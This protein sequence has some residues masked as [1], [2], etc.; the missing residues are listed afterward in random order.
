MALDAIKAATTPEDAQAAYDAVK[1]DVTAAEGED[2]QMA[3]DNRQAALAMMGRADTQKMALMDAAGMVDTSDL[4]TQEAVDAARTAIAGLRQAIADAVDV[5]DTS[6]YQSMLDNAIA[7]V[8]EAQGGIDTATRRTNQMAELS[9]ASMTLQAAL[10]AL[11]GSTP[12]QAQLDAANAAVSAL[13]AAIA[14]GADLTDAEKATYVREAANAAAPISTAQMAFDDAEGEAQRKADM[15]MAAMATKLWGAIGDMPIGGTGEAIRMGAYDADGNIEVT[16]GT[17]TAVDLSEDEDAMVE[18]NR[19]WEGMKYTVSPDGGGNYEATVYGSVPEPTPGLKFGANAGTTGAVIGDGTDPTHTHR[20]TLT[21]GRLTLSSP[22]SSDVAGSDFPGLGADTVDLEGGTPM[23]VGGALMY[24]KSYTGT[25]QGVAGTY[26][27]SG[28]AETG[29]CTITKTDDGFSLTASSASWLFQPTD[30]NARLMSTPINT[31]AYY[32]WWLH[33]D[34][35]GD[36][37]VSAFHGYRGTDANAVSDLTSLSGTATYKGGAA[38]KYAIRSGT[39]NDSGH[40]T[41]DAELNAKF[42]NATGAA[43]ADTISGTIDNFMGADGMPRNWS[44]ELKESLITDS[45]GVIGPDSTADATATGGTAWTMGGTAGSAS[46]TGRWSGQLHNVATSSG[47]P[48]DGT[49]IFHSEYGNT[50]RMVGA[51]GVNFED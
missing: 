10:A 6:M 1:D 42:S 34:A 40:F 7:A 11:S 41:A 50:G 9:G 26:I 37:T 29:S 32:G 4:S 15:E 14:A 25:Y 33:E 24:T 27:C 31:Y 49:G 51:F 30:P 13:N 3:V 23:T 46:G 35:D 28:A 22:A 20:H 2:L 19:D 38:G 47:I 39:T 48:Q 18:A 12:T 17:A 8:D 36:A 5:A 43:G 16:I 21:D 44:V 45:T